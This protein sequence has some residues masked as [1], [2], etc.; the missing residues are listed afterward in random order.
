MDVRQQ[1]NLELF[2]EFQRREID[3]AYPTQTVLLQRE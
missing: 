2:K 3:F 1:L